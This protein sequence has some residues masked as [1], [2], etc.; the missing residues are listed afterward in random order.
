[1]RILKTPL[2]LAALLC[3][4]SLAACSGNGASQTN[5]PAE[6]PQSAGTSKAADTH[7]NYATH[8]HLRFKGALLHSN[9]S[10]QFGDCLSPT[11]IKAG[12]NFPS[13][14]TGAGQW[15]I[16]VDAFGSPTIQSDL[17]TFDQQFGLPPY[18]LSIVYPGGKP[19]F[20]PNQANQVNW[21]EET[22]LDV[23]WA[24]AA[25]P[26]ANLIL[27]VANN[28]QGQ[29]IQ[30]AQEYAVQTYGGAHPGSV[31]SLSFGVQELSINGVSASGGGANNTQL[32][33]AE[34]IYSQAATLGMTVI[35][36]AGDLGANGGFSSPNPQ[37]PASDPNVIS[38]AGTNLTLFHNG[39]YRNETVWNDAKNCV[40][41][42][43]LGADGATGGALSLI[44]PTPSFQ[45]SLTAPGFSGGLP[46]R[47]AADVAYNASPNTGV[48]I[49]VG[50]ASMVKN[51]GPNGYYAVGGTS[52]GP[53]QWAAI[54]AAANQGRL[55]AGKSPLGP[56]GKSVIAA[57]YQIAA[58]TAATK[59][60]A[61]H[62]VTQGTDNGF[63]AGV[64]GYLPGTGYDLPTGLGSP[65][66]TN[67]INALIAY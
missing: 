46:S 38:V 27:V 45:M 32:A 36:S 33:S 14:A 3:G 21:A 19:S 15:I 41:P 20:N 25:A 13:T 61:F 58:N 1:M 54:V 2:A 18:S 63:P 43:L 30:S 53:P 31:L 60:P 64:T 51:L 10:P 50:F 40:S 34:A 66:V 26:Q 16:I 49:Y 59:S 57:L 6:S 12:Y 44:F 29:T 35:A 24:H 7:F 48:V 23:E 11:T 42:C 65:N 4:A 17:N 37:F 9:C 47:S 39:N 28:D 52:Q 22:T 67:L 8:P 5:L 56:G 55:A 62:D